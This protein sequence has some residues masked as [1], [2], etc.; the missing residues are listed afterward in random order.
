[1]MKRVGALLFLTTTVCAGAGIAGTA[2]GTPPLPPGQINVPGP[3]SLPTFLP[4]APFV[5]SLGPASTNRIANAT[6]SAQTVTITAG[7][8]L[9]GTFYESAGL[10]GGAVVSGSGTLVAYTQNGTEQTRTGFT[11]ATGTPIISFPAL[12]RGVNGAG[13]MTVTWAAQN[14]TAQPNAG[15]KS[16]PVSAPAHTWMANKFTIVMRVNDINHVSRIEPFQFA[17]G[18][19]MELGVTIPLAYSAPLQTLR[20]NLGAFTI[21]L[22]GDD[23]STM[24]QIECETTTPTTFGKV[25]TN[26]F[27]RL[28]LGNCRG[29]Y[30]AA[31]TQ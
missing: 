27:V 18:R 26:A 3:T 14:V 24:F 29:S 8:G 6:A 9:P 7:N 12:D 19:G 25:G 16:T 28:V 20:S 2:Y 23:G 17:P 11:F 22:N 31:A 5:V 1:M 15:T 21:Q 13:Q 30:T 4:P 10:K